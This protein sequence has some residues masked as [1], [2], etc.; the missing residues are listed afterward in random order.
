MLK[1]PLFLSEEVVEIGVVL[2]VVTKGVMVVGGVTSVELP[3]VVGVV[4][5]V[6]GEASSSVGQSYS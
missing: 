3:D 1:V 2:V 6:V 4:F 5:E